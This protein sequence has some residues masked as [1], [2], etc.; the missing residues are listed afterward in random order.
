M[1][2]L[3]GSIDTP[4]NKQSIFGSVEIKR[5]DSEKINYISI[6]VIDSLQDRYV[7]YVRDYNI[8]NIAYI[9]IRTKV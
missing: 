2:M 5:F 3:N 1:V 9:E 4:F 8:A 7:L 6:R